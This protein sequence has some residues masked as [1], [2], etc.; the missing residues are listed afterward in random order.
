MNSPAYL[1]CPTI[2][3]AA[4]KHGRNVAVVTAKDKL[5]KLLSHDLDGIAFSSEKAA[6][7]T[8]DE[9]HIENVPGLVCREVPDIYSAEASV[10]VL[11]AGVSLLEAGFTDFAYLT[12]TDYIQHKHA[13]VEE[14]AIAFYEALDEPL[15]QLLELGAVV[16]ITADHGMNGK[17]DAR[18]KP[19]VI[20]LESELERRFG[21]GCRVICPITDPYVVH[22]GALGGLVMVHIEDARQDH[23]EVARFTLSLDGITEVHDR[24][25]A[26]RKLELPAD[27]IGDL[28]VLAARD[29]AVGR[30]PEDHDLSGLGGVLR[31]HG[32]RYEEMVPLLLSEPPRREDLMRLHTDPRSFDLYTF[33]CPSPDE[34]AA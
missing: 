32:G 17:M 7:T 30:R 10:F 3:S 5:R 8:L 26:A 12:L 27:R 11:W 19:R 18:G 23:A 6:E 28:V 14:A 2:L 33:L 22:H 21:P 16:G 20:H 31:S 25:T 29:T 9:H 1:R 34:P 13:P 15:G 4:A 24:E